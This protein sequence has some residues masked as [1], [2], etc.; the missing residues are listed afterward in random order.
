MQA[1]GYGQVSTV[2]SSRGKAACHFHLLLN[3]R[4]LER[5]GHGRFIN[6]NAKGR[7]C[8]AALAGGVENIGQLSVLVKV[9]AL[10]QSLI[11]NTKTFVLL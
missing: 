1:K 10:F 6:S 3:S 11:L 4:C 8:F 7:T 9:E 5:L 2:S